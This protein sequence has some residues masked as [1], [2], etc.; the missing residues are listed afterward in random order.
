[1]LTDDKT[2]SEYFR[3]Y[4]ARH[5]VMVLRCDSVQ[6]KES[7]RNA[8]LAAGLPMQAFIFDKLC[9]RLAEEALEVADANVD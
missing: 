4:N 8:A 5:P 9:L 3:L 1:M 6:V 2:Q 7:I